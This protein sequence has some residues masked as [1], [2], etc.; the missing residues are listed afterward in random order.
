MSNLHSSH[1]GLVP[2][3]PAQ[4]VRRRRTSSAM[5]DGMARQLALGSALAAAPADSSAAAVAPLP[6]SA[7]ADVTFSA[8]TLLWIAVLGTLLGMAA[9]ALA[10]RLRRMRKDAPARPKAVLRWKSARRVASGSDGH[11]RASTARRRQRVQPVSSRSAVRWGSNSVAPAPQ[12]NEGEGVPQTERIARHISFDEL[13]RTAARASSSFSSSSSSSR[14]FG[15]RSSVPADDRS[16]ITGG[17]GVRAWSQPEPTSTAAV[18]D[19]ALPASTRRSAK[20]A[21]ESS[22]DAPPSAARRRR[23]APDA[24]GVSALLALRSGTRTRAARGRDEE[25]DEAWR[26]GPAP[27]RHHQG[28]DTPET[29]GRSERRK[30]ALPSSSSSSSDARAPSRQSDKRRKQGPS[31]ASIG[32]HRGASSADLQAALRETKI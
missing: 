18:E 12:R 1:Q 28:G 15:R 8:T 7:G 9:V 10:P 13:S 6:A 2:C 14:S 27:K 29:G 22:V 23:L 17:G 3:S 20:R 31:T 24:S 26:I 11:G 32:D 25:D 21:A 30:R 16:A 4:K 5:W 19:E